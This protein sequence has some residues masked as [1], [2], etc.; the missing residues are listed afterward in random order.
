MGQIVTSKPQYSVPQMRQINAIPWNGFTAVSTFSGCGGSSLGYRMAGFRVLWASEFIDAARDSYM[1]NAANYTIIDKR[2]IRHVKASDILSDIKL[3]PGELDLLDGSPPCS[4]FSTAGKRQKLWG[5]VKK[6]SDRSQ[7]TDDLFFEFTRLLKEIQPRTFVAE[8]V[9]GLV[10]G[11][12][13]GYFLQIL[14]ELKDCG[15][16]VSCRVLDA[17]LLGVPQGRQRTIFVGVRNDLQIK[18]VHPKPLPYIYSL[19]E[20][21]HGLN[22]PAP[23]EVCFLK[24]TSALY[25]IWKHSRIGD[26]FDIANN[27]LNKKTGMFSHRKATP[28]LPI[29]TVTTVPSIYHWLEPRYLSIPELKRACSFPD[30]FVLTGKFA[31]QWERLARA[32]PP[33]MMS[34]I[35]ASIRDNILRKYQ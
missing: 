18:P 7:R 30:D 11:A 26:G 17:R 31:D 8:N 15:F 2:D 5:Q 10:I 33:I 13:K 25:N 24:P 32:V 4:S 12:A 14:K 20:C 1:Q 29:P 19:G 35:A 28:A 6:Y 21:L 16:Q 3:N 9:R 27:R 34:H 23:N 22:Q